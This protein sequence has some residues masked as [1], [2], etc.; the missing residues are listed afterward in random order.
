MKEIYLVLAGAMGQEERMSQIANNLANVNTVGFKKEGTVF[1]DYFRAAQAQA[2]AG[3]GGEGPE[4]PSGQVWPTGALNYIELGKGDFRQTGQ[5]LDAALGSDGFFMVEV[6]GQDN[7]LYT[8][9]GN[10]H[11]NSE[12]GLV[13]PSGHS[14][15]DEGERPIQLDLS[16]G[17]LTITTEGE[18]MVGSQQVGRLGVVRFEDPGQ[19]IK[20]GEGMFQAPEGLQAEQM[21]NP[22]V[23]QGM[24]EGSN[25]RPIEEMIRMIQVQR[26]YETHQKLM[27]TI[28]DVTG[29][30]IDAARQA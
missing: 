7:P 9:A 6:D 2:Q 15:L 16:Q 3:Q 8:R 17:V 25:V 30:R 18:M 21:E 27:Q 11:M 14:V 28:D 13:T 1:L 4:N 24:L 19:L 5:P 12:G 26:A 22:Q 20:Y 29:K 23:R 10:F